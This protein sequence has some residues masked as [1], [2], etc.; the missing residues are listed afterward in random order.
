MFN[1]LLSQISDLQLSASD[2]IAQTAPQSF[3]ISVWQ[4]LT[5]LMVGAR[6]HICADE[7]VRDPAL[8]V[9]EI[10]REGVTILQIVPA[11]LRRILERTP[12]EPVFR[13]LSRF[14]CLISTGEPLTPDLCRDWFR[15]FP[16][17][18]LMNAYGSRSVPTMWQRIVSRR[19]RR[20]SPPCRLAAPIA[21]TA[22]MCSMPIWSRCRS[23]SRELYVGGIG[24]GRGYLNDP[25]QTRRSFL[26]DPFS[27]R[28]A[29]VCTGPGTWPAGAPT[30]RL[31][32]LAAS[33][34]K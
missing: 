24:V 12:K 32:A 26:R 27:N 16:D 1:H 20:R 5:A 4:F 34:T 7:E 10:A 13:A 3:V 25:E 19:R 33:T 2:V 29:R 22:F 31:N 11:L 28:R 23:G 9:Q 14:R 17:V 21:N 15:H 8:L 6:V 30:E 18:P